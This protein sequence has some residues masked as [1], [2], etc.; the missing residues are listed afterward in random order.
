MFCITFVCNVASGLFLPPCAG[1]L[2]DVP[3]SIFTNIVAYICN[4]CTI[5]LPAM[6]RRHSVSVPSS[7]SSSLRSSPLSRAPVGA[8]LL[9][10]ERFERLCNFINSR[11]DL[12]APV[13]PLYILASGGYGSRLCENVQIM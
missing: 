3:S 8:R 4:K 11:L 2:Q 9:L 1:T 5:G 12:L 13:R 10:G 6:T 7:S